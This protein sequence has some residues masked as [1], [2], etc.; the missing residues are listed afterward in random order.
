MDEVKTE[1]IAEEQIQEKAPTAVTNTVT[2]ITTNI[3]N[4]VFSWMD[5]ATVGKLYKVATGLASTPLVP[6]TY[7]NKPWAIMIA[8]ELAQRAKMPIMTVLQNLYIVQGKPAWSGSFCITAINNS[9]LFEPLDFLW[10]NGDD[11]NV[12]GC[13]AQA[14]RISDGKL[15]QSAPITWETVQGFGWEK[16]AGSMWNIPGQREQMYMYRSASFFARAFCPDV[17]NGLYTVEEQKDISGYQ[18]KPEVVEIKIGDKANG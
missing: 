6:D 12:I 5:V 14:K 1:T 15:C 7:R 13:I 10:M 11:G 4:S 18:E 2:N 3:E 17:L 9:G 8:M 16:K